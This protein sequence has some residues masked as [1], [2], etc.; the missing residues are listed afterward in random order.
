M[1]NL[2]N[3]FIPN[4]PVDRA[5][6]RNITLGWVV[7][8]LLVWWQSPFIFLPKPGEVSAALHDLWFYQNLAD[9][10]FSSL[11]LDIESIA[12]ATVISLMFAY[13]ST[14]SLFAPVVSFIG[15]MRFLSFY[16]LGFAFT[17]MATSSQEMKISVLVFMVVVYFVVSMV[18]ILAQ[19]P[20]EQYDLAKTLKMGAWETLWEVVIFGQLD[21][22]F[23]VTRQTAAM[24]FMFL[25]TA[26]EMNMSGGGIGTILSTSNKHFHM[27][28]VMAIQMV[29]LIIGLAQDWL[30]GKARLTCCPWV[31]RDSLLE[32]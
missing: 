17:L 27:A 15:K 5:M 21:Q 8:A 23:I 18:D 16:G 9:G 30:I 10:I 25:A 29:V 19:I 24:A 31:V 12:I 20:Q 2:N 3:I 14:M 13:L 6:R 32:R 22:A 11:M 28:E 1:T 4:A 7:C 26:E